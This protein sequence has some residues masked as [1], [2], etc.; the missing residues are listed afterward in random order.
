MQE[1]GAVAGLFLPFCPALRQVSR[2]RIDPAWVSLA[3]HYLAQCTERNSVMGSDVTLS[4]WNKP[5]G[6]SH[7]PVVYG[8]VAEPCVLNPSVL[9]TF[10][11]VVAQFDAP[12]PHPLGWE[13][14]YFLSLGVWGGEK[15]HRPQAGLRMGAGL[16]V[17][18]GLW[19]WCLIIYVSVFFS[20]TSLLSLHSPLP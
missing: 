12:S 10:L 4:C 15:L 20:P 1:G 6:R 19:A 9:P 7:S 8:W 5:V 14:P 16:S 2:M 11:I 17:C 13:S 3:W 18:M